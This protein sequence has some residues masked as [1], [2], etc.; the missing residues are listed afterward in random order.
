MD[1]L[2]HNRQYSAELVK[3]LPREFFQPVPQRLL[4]LLPFLATAVGS[5]LAISLLQLPLIVNLILAVVIGCSFASLSFLGHEILHGSVVRNRWLRDVIG[6]AC[7]LHFNLGPKLWRRW[8]NAEHHAHT[9][10]DKD[11]PDAMGTLE[12]WRERPALRFLY[13]LAPWLRSF[14]TFSSFTFWFSLHSFAMLRR[15]FRDFKPG[16]RFSVLAQFIG[17]VAFWALLLVLVGPAKFTFIYLVPVV[18]ANFTV[19]SY[20]ATNHLLNPLADVNDPLVTSLTVR[21]PRW[22]DVLHFNFSHHT[23]HHVF[24]GMNPKFAPRVKE[25]LRE[26]WPERYNEM[27]HW[28]ALA[29]LWRTPRLY[30]DRT[31]LIDPGHGTVFPTLGRGLDPNQVRPTA[32]LPGEPQR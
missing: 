17:P 27:P 23:E 28:K 20:I 4:W 2:W 14:L 8:H 7:F 1:T 18:I 30:R 10:D 25:L 22:V 11:D 9:Q 29:A 32:V 5:M 15:F 21:V 24:P 3:R 19:M 6:G 31:S 13:R 16:D 12:D 26:L